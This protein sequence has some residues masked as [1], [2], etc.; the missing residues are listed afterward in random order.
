MPTSREGSARVITASGYIRA[1]LE[2]MRQDSFYSVTDTLCKLVHYINRDTFLTAQIEQIYVEKNQDFTLI[3]KIGD[4]EILFG[5]L[6]GM[7]DKFRRLK[8][9][10]REAL[11]YEGWRKYQKINL[12]YQ[13]QVV[14]IK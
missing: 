13:K 5:K 11:P 2:P 9:F 8:I 6:N 3:P 12:K 4:S 1:G 7:E 14:G 10:Y